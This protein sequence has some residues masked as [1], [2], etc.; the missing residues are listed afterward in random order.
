[1][2]ER[3]QARY[4][5]LSPNTALLFGVRNT[6]GYEPFHLAA[7]RELLGDWETDPGNS[8]DGLALSGT[9][10]AVVPPG[11]AIPGWRRAELLQGGWELLEKPSPRTAEFVVDARRASG[12]WRTLLSAAPA[13]R[14]APLGEGWNRL[15]LSVTTTG[16]AM[17][18]PGILGGEGWI[19]KVAGIRAPAGKAGGIFA[20]VPVPAGHSMVEMAYRPLPF[21]VGLLLSAVL[22]A[23]LLA[24]ALLSR[25][26]PSR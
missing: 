15:T 9:R 7:L 23:A 1:M 16:T 12:P 14:V 24:G 11:R 17:L 18:V 26:P 4:R 8:R 10:W 6:F 25:L 20:A 22:A 19:A 5:M 3:Y 2:L 13:G 21:G